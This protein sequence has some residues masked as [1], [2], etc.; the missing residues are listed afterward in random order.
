MIDARQRLRLPSGASSTYFASNTE[1]VVAN[2][3]RSF[4]ES[5]RRSKPPTP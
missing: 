4:C 5:I 3:Y 2:R 1:T